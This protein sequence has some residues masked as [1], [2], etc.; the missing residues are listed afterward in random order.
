M[1]MPSTPA[2]IVSLIF[3][4]CALLSV[5]CAWK[6]DWAGIIQAPVFV[7]F[8][9]LYL[10]YGMTDIPHEIRQSQVRIGLVFVGASIIITRVIWIWIG[11]RRWK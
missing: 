8:A 10:H 9:L 7:A 1:T 11:V 2:W 4:I 6:G 3:L 5:I